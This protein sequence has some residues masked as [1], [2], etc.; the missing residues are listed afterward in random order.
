M[1]SKINRIFFD[2]SLGDVIVF[3]D[4][5]LDVKIIKWFI[6]SFYIYVVIVLENKYFNL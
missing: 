4:N 5:G 6:R 2:I 1:S 3:W